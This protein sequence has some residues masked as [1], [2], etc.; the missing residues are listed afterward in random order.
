METS[1]HTISLIE[2]GLLWVM[3]SVSLYSVYVSENPVLMLS[4]HFLAFLNGFWQF[5]PS[6]YVIIQNSKQRKMVQ[7][8]IMMTCFPLRLWGLGAPTSRSTILLCVYPT[9]I[10]TLY[11]LTVLEPIIPSQFQSSV[12]FMMFCAFGSQVQFGFEDALL[13]GILSAMFFT[14]SVSL[15]EYRTHLSHGSIYD[16]FRLS[17][18]HHEVRTPANGLVCAAGIIKEELD[19]LLKKPEF[20]QCCDVSTTASVQD[21]VDVMQKCSISLTEVLDHMLSYQKNSAG[22]HQTTITSFEL[23]PFLLALEQTIQMYPRKENVQLYFLHPES[24]QWPSHPQKKRR[25]IYDRVVRTDRDAL[26]QILMNLLTNAIKFTNQ[27]FIRFRINLDEKIPGNICF[28]IEDSGEGMSEQFLKNVFVPFSQ[29]RDSLT[30]DIR[31]MGLGLTIC[32]MLTDRLHGTIDIK[33]KKGDGTQVYLSIPC[34][35]DSQIQ[36]ENIPEQLTDVITT[37]A[38]TPTTAKKVE[39]LGR[40][41]VCLIVD[42]NSVNRKVI[43]GLCS[44]TGFECLMECSGDDAI[45][46][47]RDHPGKVDLILM[48]IFMPGT[49]GIKAASMIRDLDPQKSPIIVACTADQSPENVEQYKDAG[50]L[51]AIDKPV[52]KESLIELFN[53]FMP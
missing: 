29:E 17:S 38:L 18:L 51:R 3:M 15:T 25:S 9:V 6:S 53:L 21:W 1:L 42:D 47:V 32:R 8:I 41:P 22:F 27:G 49:N 7:F 33:S 24:N 11:R 44:R 50:I 37:D 28:I 16:N 46:Y 2:R 4:V 31:G 45:V 40:K 36:V 19:T 26:Q 12:I 10:A 35:Q 23:K 5:V 39:I 30:S 43:A 52:K 13:M 14:L 48:D 34:S 20:Q